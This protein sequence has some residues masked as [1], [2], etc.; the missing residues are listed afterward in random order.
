VAYF[1]EKGLPESLQL[2]PLEYFDKAI[3]WMGHNNH[4]R[5]GGI[6][7]V[8]A[9]R[10]AELALLLASIKTGNKRSYSAVAQLRSLEWHA[11]GTAGSPVFSWTLGGKPVPFM[12]YDSTKSIVPADLPAVYKLFESSWLKR[13][14]WKWLPSKSSTFADLCCW[15]PATTMQSGR[16][17]RWVMRFV[18]G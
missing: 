1:K 15:L 3:D 11:K 13:R 4:V 17:T 8:G 10:G 12:P 14:R 6:I 2:I 7:V 9:S 5:P 18:H 16:R